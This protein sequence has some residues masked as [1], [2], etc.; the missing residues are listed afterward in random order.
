M[1]VVDFIQNDLWALGLEVLEEFV[2][3]S[4]IHRGD[5]QDTHSYSASV[6]KTDESKVHGRQHQTKQ[7]ATDRD[8]LYAFRVPPC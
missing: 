7:N 4:Q 8:D 2:V 3:S 5:N 1:P 6:R